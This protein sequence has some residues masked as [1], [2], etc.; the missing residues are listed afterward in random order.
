MSWM[1]CL[2]QSFIPYNS[3]Q[4]QL[5]SCHQLLNEQFSL[6]S[7]LDSG[8]FHSKQGSVIQ[9]ILNNGSQ[10]SYEL[11]YDK[12]MITQ[13]IFPKYSQ[14]STHSLPLRPRCQVVSSSVVCVG[15]FIVK[16]LYKMHT[17]TSW[18]LINKGATFKGFTLLFLLIVNL[19]FDMCLQV[20]VAIIEVGI[21]G[22]YDCTNILK[23]VVDVR[24]SETDMQCKFLIVSYNIHHINGLVQERHNSSALAME[25]RLSCIN[26]TTHSVTIIRAGYRSDYELT[27]DTPYLALT[28][29]LWTVFSEF[30]SLLLNMTQHTSLLWVSTVLP[31]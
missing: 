18:C 23:W 4:H 30:C 12:Y 25:L 8:S 16:E 13:P 6:K 15:H 29:E 3:Y 7:R 22:Q 11:Y 2:T 31:F 27:K 24:Y 17:H 21:G 1:W 14:K 20:D 26:P 10:A 19:C 9:I 5:L 28:G